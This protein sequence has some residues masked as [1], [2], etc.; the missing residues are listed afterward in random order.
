M[1]PKVLLSFVYAVDFYLFIELGPWEINIIYLP[2][3]RLYFKSSLKDI[4]F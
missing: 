1:L 3:A 2:E 4:L